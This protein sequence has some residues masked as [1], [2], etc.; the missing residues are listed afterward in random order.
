MSYMSIYQIEDDFASDGS[1]GIANFVTSMIEPLEAQ[2]RGFSHGH[3]KTTGVP[4]SRVANLK[5][6][7]AEQ[8]SQLQVF[9]SKLRAEVLRAAETLQYD[10]ATEVARQLSV[11]VPAEPFTR[12]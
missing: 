1:P 5:R 12:K 3:K 6:L 10:S 7:F 8:D 4:A 2:G 11:D 9:M